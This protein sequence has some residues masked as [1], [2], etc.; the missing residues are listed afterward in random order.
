LRWAPVAIDM[1]TPALKMA[2]ITK[3]YSAIA[4]LSNQPW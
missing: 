4:R 3:L 2:G 1:K